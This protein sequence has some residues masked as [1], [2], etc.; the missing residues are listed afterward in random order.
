MHELVWLTD[1][2]QTNPSSYFSWTFASLFPA[3]PDLLKAVVEFRRLMHVP[4]KTVFFFPLNPNT[5]V[6]ILPILSPFLLLLFL[7]SAFA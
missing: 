7:Q 6:T 2:A 3:I 1:T 5:L 4:A